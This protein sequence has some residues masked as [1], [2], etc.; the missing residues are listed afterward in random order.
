MSNSQPAVEQTEFYIQIQ[1]SAEDPVDLNAIIAAIRSLGGVE[2][3]HGCC[4][5]SCEQRAAVVEVLGEK[6]G[7]RYFSIAD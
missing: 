5:S 4:F 1:I 3:E 6:F 7:S 2:T